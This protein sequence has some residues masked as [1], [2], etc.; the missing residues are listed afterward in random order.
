MRNKQEVTSIWVKL[1][2]QF[3]ASSD[4]LQGQVREMVVHSILNGLIPADIAIP[5]SRA[6]AQALGVSR[7]TVSL[8]LQML[9]DKG[10]LVS[11]ERSGLFVNRDILLGQ[12]SRS[13]LAP[14]PDTSIDWTSRLTS[15]L[16]LQRNI[17]KPANWQDFRYPFLYGQFDASLMPLKDWRV[18]VKQSLLAPAVKK[19]SRDF[20]NRDYDPLVDQIL[21]RLLPARG[22]VA[23]R[24]EIL[25]TAGAQMA[26]YMLANVLLGPNTVVGIEDPG[27]PDARN[28]FKARS[29]QVRS[30]PIDGDGLMASKR[31]EQCAY[32][33]VTP[34]HQCPTGVTM[35]LHRRHAILEMARKKNIV[36]FEDDH[37]S[38]LNFSG[39]PLPALK[40]LD[41]EGRVI[42]L[43]SFSKTLAQG[44]RLGFIVGP[45]DLIRELRALRRLILRHVPTNNAH[46]A[47]LFIAQGHHDALIRKLNTTFRERRAILKEALHHYLPQY[48]MSNAVG[49]SSAWIHGAGGL[50]ANDL[51]KSCALRGVLIEPGAIFFNKTSKANLPFFRMGYAAIQ[52]SLI[53]A[54]VKELFLA[55]REL[56]SRTSQIGNPT[57]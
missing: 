38:E 16:D 12:A 56:V 15:S 5:P 10:F 43:G 9:V 40:S 57:A 30:L 55:S 3:T 35:P 2:P 48:Q 13:A 53:S 7:N 29:S 47:S 28:N 18:C 24:D 19:W 49:G 14:S 44:M 51:A 8:A 22:I 52:S 50:D 34:S 33:Y 37:E 32:A 4:T 31:L 6:L 42:Y 41:T 21:Y 20:I 11:R 39:R 27:Y 36:L 26:C 46:V 17:V 45:A 54:G 25:V 23:Q 1:F